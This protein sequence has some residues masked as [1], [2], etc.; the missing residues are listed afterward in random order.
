M[1]Y[2]ETSQQRKLSNDR[3][4]KGLLHF[5][6]RETRYL[7]ATTALE[8]RYQI[9]CVA[10]SKLIVV[11]DSG[12]VYPCEILETRDFPDEVL[13]RFGGNFKIGNVRDYDCDLM[14]MVRSDRGREIVRFILESK[15]YCTFECAIAA[16]IV[17][18]PRTLIKTAIAPPSRAR[19]IALR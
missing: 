9:P 3:I 13:E 7:T 14:Q 8:D 19:P 5:V 16:S 17:F 11:Y 12:D 6:E 2:L 18:N 1:A 15:C 4:H 10:G